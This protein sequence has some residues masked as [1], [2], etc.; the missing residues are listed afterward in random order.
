MFSILLTLIRFI[1]FFHFTRKASTSIHK[2]MVHNIITSTMQFFDL[3]LIG[4]VLTRF[5]KDFV[6]VDETFPFV[7]VECIIASLTNFKK[8]TINN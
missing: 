4:N 8:K 2:T 6:T 7:I 5:S 1:G 3:H